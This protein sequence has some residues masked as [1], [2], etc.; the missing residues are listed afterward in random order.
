[1]RN[2]YI[3]RLAE[4]LLGA[5]LLVNILVTVGGTSVA[6]APPHQ[7]LTTFLKRQDG[8][9]QAASAI[10]ATLDQGSREGWRLVQIDSHDGLGYIILVFE[11]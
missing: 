11:K 6:S 3:T 9:A 7:Y 5:L 8:P 10:Q 4:F 2:G 1:M